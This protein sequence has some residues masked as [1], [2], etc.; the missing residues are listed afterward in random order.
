VLAVLA[1][2][3]QARGQGSQQASFGVQAAFSVRLAVE[4]LTAT[5]FLQ[6]VLATLALAQ[7]VVVCAFTDTKQV[8]KKKVNKKDKDFMVI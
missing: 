1:V 6:A 3:Q 4:A 7:P 2:A 5:A 8:Q